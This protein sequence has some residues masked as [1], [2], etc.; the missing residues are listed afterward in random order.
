VNN[1]PTPSLAAD[2]QP[3]ALG[4]RSQFVRFAVAGVAGL[5]ADVV[6]LYAMLA[7]GLGMFGGRTIS[8]LSAVWVTFMLNRRFTF[9]RRSDQSVWGEWW[10]YLG[11]M[12]AGGAVNYAAYSAVVV[13]FP[14]LPF[15]PLL[16]VAAGSLA[17]MSVNFVSAKFLV[18]R[19]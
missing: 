10:R 9:G 4:A 6:V 12:I 11:A 7:L 16:A 8:F 5:A 19:R 15:L 3:A 17:G 2:G 1:V 13:L 18:F 14:K